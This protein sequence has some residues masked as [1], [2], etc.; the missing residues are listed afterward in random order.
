MGTMTN[1]EVLYA[2]LFIATFPAL[3][4]LA[5][6]FDHILPE[7]SRHYSSREQRE[8]EQERRLDQPPS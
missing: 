5:A 7:L 4:I 3:W 8:L 2:V 1:S 6:V